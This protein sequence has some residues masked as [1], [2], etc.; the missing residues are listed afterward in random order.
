[1]LGYSLRRSL[2][3]SLDAYFLLINNYNL[4]IYAQ[5]HVNFKY[6]ISGLMAITDFSDKSNHIVKHISML[7]M[8]R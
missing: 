2:L 5:Y 7:K 8:A 1:M 4:T 6:R 3:S